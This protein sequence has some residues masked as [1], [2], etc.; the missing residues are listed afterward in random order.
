[1]NH[2]IQHF[3]HDLNNRSRSISPKRERSTSPELNSKG[4]ISRTPSPEI[5]KIV[6]SRRIESNEIIRSFD[7][8]PIKKMPIDNLASMKAYW[9]KAPKKESSSEEEKAPVKKAPVKKG[10]KQVESSE[11]DENDESSE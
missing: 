4:E 3:D 6:R 8:E 1:M 7:P 5:K 9:D 10:K 2:D 11:E